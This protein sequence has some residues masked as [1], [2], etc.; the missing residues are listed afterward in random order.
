MDMTIDMTPAAIIEA[1]R[2]YGMSAKGIATWGRDHGR[3]F[4]DNAINSIAHRNSTR[5]SKPIE[6]TLQELYK[7]LCK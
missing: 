2:R 1:L 7:R 3:D 5:I 6:E 4:T